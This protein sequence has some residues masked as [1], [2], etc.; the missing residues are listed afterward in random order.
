VDLW[1]ELRVGTAGN[2]LTRV[3]DRLAVSCIVFYS[4]TPLGSVDYSWMVRCLNCSV[5]NRPC[6]TDR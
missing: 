5:I 2:L 3:C 4:R 6:D 1:I